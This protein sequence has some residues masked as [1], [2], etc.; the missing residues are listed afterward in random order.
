M[1]VRT[2]L[3]LQQSDRSQRD[4]YAPEGAVEQDGHPPDPARGQASRAVN[5]ANNA[6]LREHKAAGPSRVI[7]P[8]VRCSSRHERL[9]GT[10]GARRRFER[11][12]DVPFSSERKLMSTIHH[13][14]QNLARLVVFTKGTWMCCKPLLPRARRRCR[15]AVDDARRTAIR[16]PPRAGP[17]R[18]S[19][20]SVAFRSLPLMRSSTE[21]TRASSTTSCSWVWSG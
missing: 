9:A 15:E 20:R 3:T 14:A 13:D 11:V 8:K 19:V 5:L 21:S 12:A 1:T 2:V 4:R 6:T 7:R 18:R 17:A 10:G 16:P